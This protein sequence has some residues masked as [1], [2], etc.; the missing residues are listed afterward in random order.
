MKQSY[1]DLIELFSSASLG[2]E[3]SLNNDVNLI[4]IFELANNA[5]IWPIVFSA[6][7]KSK[8]KI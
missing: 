5:N 8:I 1:L 3:L 6:I 4:E 2:R 7:K